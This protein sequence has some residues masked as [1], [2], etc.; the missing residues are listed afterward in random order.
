M[1]IRKIDLPGL[2]STWLARARLAF[3]D[4]KMTAFIAISPLSGRHPVRVRALS[5]NHSRNKT[6]CLSSS[7]VSGCGVTFRPSHTNGS[8]IYSNCWRTTGNQENVNGIR[9]CHEIYRKGDPLARIQGGF[10]M[11]AEMQC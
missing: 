9:L 5:Q 10:S 3:A 8:D 11:I 6:L 7:P 2:F 4:L 1:G